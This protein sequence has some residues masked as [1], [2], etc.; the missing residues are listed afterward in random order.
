MKQKRLTAF[1]AASASLVVAAGALGQCP[2]DVGRLFAAGAA[3]GDV[4]GVRVAIDGDTAIVG[5]SGYDVVPG[6]IGHDGAAYIFVRRPPSG[7]WVEQARLTA[8]DGE[9][10]DLFGVDVAISG[11]VAVV[12]AYMPAGAKTGAAYVF[13]RSGEAWSEVAKLTASDGAGF[14]YFGISVATDGE[15][16]VVGAPNH[17]TGGLINAGAAY[18]FER[19]GA[20]WSQKKKLIA[21]DRAISNAFGRTVAIDG[22]IIVVGADADDTPPSSPFVVSFAGTAYAFARSGGQWVEEAI[23][24]PVT[25]GF[26]AQFGN[27]IAISGE[28][29]LIGEPHRNRPAGRFFGAA[30][31]FQRSGGAWTREAEFIASDG[32][33][34]DNFGE[35]VALD[36]DVAIIGA[37]TRDTGAA[38]DAGAAYLLMREGGS[39]SEVA[40]LTASDGAAGDR[41]GAVAL[42]SGVAI[43]GAYLDDTVGGTDAGSAY[44][45]DLD[46][47][48]CY[49]DCDGSSSLE[50]FDFLC[51][52]DAFAAGESY[53]DCDDSGALNFFDFLCFQ[54]AF[55]A[56]CAF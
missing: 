45:F 4:F 31:V 14:D 16:I 21:S 24:E 25:P 1:W 28:T 32:A 22:D 33:P 34:G 18:I 38:A 47:P 40:T 54:D 53:A 11:D 9:P 6:P 20:K 39:W 17:D 5:A 3:P 15:A 23:L 10:L 27:A 26:Q 44:I 43:V 49:A 30:Y 35:R 19:S 48:S 50:F 36:G 55:A 2:E 52:Q 41:F 51:F 56:G 7:E 46:C 13:E 8:S 42:D 12:G 37:L 29:V